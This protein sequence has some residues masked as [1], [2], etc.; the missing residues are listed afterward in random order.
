[1]PPIQSFDRARRVISLGTF[2]KLVSPGLRVGWV[3][4]PKEIVD[5]MAVLKTDGG[6][7]PLT[8]RIILEFLKGGQLPRH[9]RDLVKIYTERR[10]VMVRELGVRLPRTS[11]RLPQGGYYVWLRL[12]DEW[13]ADHILP[14]ALRHG[15]RYYPASTFYATKGPANFMR[16]SYS[17]CTVEEIQEGV[18]RLADAV[19]ESYGASA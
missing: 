13:D 16:L 18:R 12:P 8:Q 10:D 7:C 3:T 19:A 9:T 17:F 11:C 2:S 1:V 15:V 14:A 6:S 5:K 4:G